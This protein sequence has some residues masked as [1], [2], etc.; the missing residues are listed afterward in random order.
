MLKTKKDTQQ[1]NAYAWISL[2]SG[3]LSLFSIPLLPFFSLSLVFM[4][5]FINRSQHLAQDM[6]FVSLLVVIIS[7]LISLILFL[8]PVIAIISGIIAILKYGSNRELGGLGKAVN[9]IVLGAAVIVL[10]ILIY[11]SVTK[12]NWIM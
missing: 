6:L 3:I 7:A 2:I 8:L 10:L 12:M 11:S 4:I 5:E 1:G 9:G